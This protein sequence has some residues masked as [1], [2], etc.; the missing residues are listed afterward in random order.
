MAGE[1]WQPCVSVRVFSGKPHI[2]ELSRND[3]PEYLARTPRGRGGTSLQL[4]AEGFLSLHVT[5]PGTLSLSSGSCTSS[6][7]GQRWWAL[8]PFF[9]D[10][11]WHPQCWRLPSMNWAVFANYC[12]P[13][14]RCL[15]D[16]ESQV[17]L[18]C[19]CPEYCQTHFCGES[20]LTDKSMPGL[21][22]VGVFPLVLMVVAGNQLHIVWSFSVLFGMTTVWFMLLCL[23]KWFFHVEVPKVMV[24]FNLFCIIQSLLLWTDV[25]AK[26]AGSKEA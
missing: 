3:I 20:C 24:S 17:P 26:A 5:T 7:L 4:G 13:A 10:L 22:V 18:S 11:E 9:F 8:G 14:C 12:G 2:G 25:I 23:L 19:L 15:Q 21:L 6:L 16:A 1:V